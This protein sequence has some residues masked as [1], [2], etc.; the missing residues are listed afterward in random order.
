MATAED[1]LDKEDI[2]LLSLLCIDNFIDSSSYSSDETSGDSLLLTVSTIDHCE[3][4]PY[5]MA[6]FLRI[7]D[8]LAGKVQRREYKGGRPQLTLEKQI[9]IALWYFANT[10]CYR[11]IASRFD[12]ND[13]TVMKS[14]DG[15]V[16]AMVKD[17]NKLIR[18]PK[19]EQLR[20][21]ENG[22]RAFQG[23]PG[24]VG[25]IDGTHIA[26]PGPNQHHE[27]NINRKGFHS[28]VAQVVCDHEMKFMSVNTGWP[29]SV[30]DARVF[31][32]SKIGKRI[33]NK[34]ILPDEF[35][36][37]GD[38]AY[39][40]SQNLMTPFKDFG[41]LTREQ[42]RYN[43]VQSSTLM[44]VEGSIGQLKGRFRKLKM[45]D[46]TL[47][48]STDSVTF[49]CILHNICITEGDILNDEEIIMDD[50]VNNGPGL[51]GIVESGN[52]KENVVQNL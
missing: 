20:R 47:P 22:F 45:L 27:N 12:V 32:N 48:K 21:N 11:S 15:I 41:T 13:S 24:V 4:C 49:C 42:Q 38:A 40:L 34:T 29:G 1:D 6:L 36:L 51:Q 7:V 33:I 35:H 50:H 28:T 30:H 3:K 31:R 25:A 18:W 16:S 46:C 17:K 5:V 37:V 9:L 26:I 52:Q 43:F 39:P 19:A 2:A 23:M 8:H 44:V 14:V 10:E